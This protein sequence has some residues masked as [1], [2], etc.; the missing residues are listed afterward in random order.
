M[1]RAIVTLVIMLAGA[2]AAAQDVLQTVKLADN[3][4]AVLQPFDNR[5]NDSNSVVIIGPASV[6]VIDSQVGEQSAR[7]VITEI[8]K[9]TD[10]PVRHV[11]ATHWHGD[12]F[13]GNQAYRDAYPGVEFIAQ[14]SAAA[15][16]QTRA[17]KLREDD[18]AEIRKELPAADERLAKGV[19]RKGQPLT[20]EG[21]HGRSTGSWLLPSSGCTRS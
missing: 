14:A 20:A 5:F 11:V 10:R 18:L 2:S 12:H 8:K 1:R 7:A 13:Q 17:T 9:L 16:M 15:D 3:V 19:D 6:M 21:R 4:Y